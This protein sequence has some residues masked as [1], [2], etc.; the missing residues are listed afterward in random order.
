MGGGAEAL[1]PSGQGL[2]EASLCPGEGGLASG[3]EGGLR[4]A[5]LPNEVVQ[6]H[7]NL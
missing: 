2:N 7:V 5:R 6:D 3:G 4:E 1:D